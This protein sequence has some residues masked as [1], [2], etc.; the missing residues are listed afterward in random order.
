[1][2]RSHLDRKECKADAT[3]E[4]E[5]VGDDPED[6]E[7]EHDPDNDPTDDHEDE[8]GDE[9]EPDP[10]DLLVKCEPSLEDQ[11]SGNQSINQSINPSI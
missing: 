1:M 6:Q 8:E 3:E 7:A 4:E 2:F 11:P 5:N 9:L 10:I